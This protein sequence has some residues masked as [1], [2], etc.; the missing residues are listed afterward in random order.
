MH[1]QQTP[2]SANAPRRLC[3][4]R[5][6]A[7]GDCCNMVPI[8]RTLQAHLPDT[9]LTWIMGQTEAGLLGDLDGVEIITHD[10]KTGTGTLRR[11]LSGRAFDVLLLMQVALR[12]G[13]ASRAVKAPVRIGFDRSRSRDGHRVFINERIPNAPPGHVIDGFFGFCEALGVQERHLRWDIPVPNSARERSEELLARFGGETSGTDGDKTA[14]HKILLISPC[15]S[16]RFRNFRNWAPEYY[17]KVASYAASVHGLR[18]VLTG[19]RSQVERDYGER[20]LAALNNPSGQKV[21]VPIL[22][23]I[24]RTDLK[25]LFALMQRA[26]VVLAPDSGPLHMAV[27]A[28]TPPIGLYATSN[29]ERTG[30]VLGMRWVVN[31]YPQAVRES[32]GRAVGD[33][34]WGKRVRDPRAMELIKPAAVIA[35]LDELMST[36]TKERLAV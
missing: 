7:I 28:G 36:P 34:R 2:V 30:P 35:K 33:I 17:A 24:G 10:K 18:I 15:S 20:I 27:A 1:H 23:L 9:R 12:A 31:A 32:L 5:L 11:K 29:P 4:F 16:D 13:L 14:A 19:G 22:N 26:S 21:P 8:V 3:L 6:S 25:T